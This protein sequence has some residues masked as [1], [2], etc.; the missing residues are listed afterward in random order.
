MYENNEYTASEYNTLKKCL[1]SITTQY[2]IYFL[3]NYSMVLTYKIQTL[4]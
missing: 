2:E 3:S 1:A 4:M